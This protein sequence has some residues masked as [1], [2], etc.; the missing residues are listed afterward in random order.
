MLELALVEDLHDGWDDREGLCL[1]RALSGR[2]GHFA[3]RG[4]AW[5]DVDRGPGERLGGLTL[6][7]L[8]SG[9]VRGVR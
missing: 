1:G 7:G 2:G 6:E 8:L 4:R 9:S 5:G 3:G